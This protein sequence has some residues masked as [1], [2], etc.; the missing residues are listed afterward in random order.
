MD[1]QELQRNRTWL[2]RVENLAIVRRCRTLIRDEFGITLRLDAPDLL[3]QIQ[4]YSSRSR[5]AELR[6]VAAPITRELVRSSFARV[7][8][9]DLAH[10]PVVAA[11]PPHTGWNRPS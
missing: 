9:P 11:R 5:V 1:T 3:E 2:L 8:G 7:E 4:R 10:I 6:Q